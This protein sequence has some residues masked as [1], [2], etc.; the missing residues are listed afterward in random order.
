MKL[1]RS[2]QKWLRS[3]HILFASLWIG[4]AIAIS[5]KQFFVN[6]SDG[7]EL[8]GILATLNFIDYFILVPGAIGCFVT[9]LIYSSMTQWGWFKHRWMVIKWI[10]CLYGIIFGTY[11]LG[12][13]LDEMTE[14]SRN[15]GMNAFS[16]PV[17]LKNMKL[18]MIFGSFQALTIIIAA[19]FSVFKP[20]KR[21]SAH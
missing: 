7:R 21:V 5:V 19:F 9:A 13:W 10:I 16:D 2:G 17:F 15:S 1:G 6:P 12:P 18:M 3:F 4:S 14:I 8:Y 20:W 11:P